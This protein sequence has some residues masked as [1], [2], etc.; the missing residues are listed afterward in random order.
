MG[1]LGCYDGE[2]HCDEPGCQESYESSDFQ[3]F[4]KFLS[5]AKRRGW[6]IDLSMKSISRGQGRCL[7]PKHATKEQ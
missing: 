7:C 5:E 3:T 4:S 2:L 1:F 6:S